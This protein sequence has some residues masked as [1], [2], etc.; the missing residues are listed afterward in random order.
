[1]YLAVAVLLKLGHGDVLAVAAAADEPSRGDGPTVVVSWA[2]ALGALPI[3]V[4]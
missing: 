4:C 3:G 1:V 2:H